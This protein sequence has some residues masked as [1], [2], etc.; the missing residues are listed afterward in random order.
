M[1]Y[2]G[3]GPRRGES[4]TDYSRRLWADV[5]PEDR[6][7]CVAIL[8]DD[9]DFMSIAPKVRSKIAEEPNDWLTA[10]HFGWGMA[11][12]NLLRSALMDKDLPIKEIS[13]DDYYS[14]TIEE[15]LG[16]WSVDGADPG[17]DP[18]PGWLENLYWA[19]RRRLPG[20]N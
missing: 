6:K 18:E 9:E 2:P 7:R 1:S 4:L 15:A 12:R 13:W 16:I 10:Y 11:V 14:A 19:I 20:G 3:G 17:P 5:P 8:H